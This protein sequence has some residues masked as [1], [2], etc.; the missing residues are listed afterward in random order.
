IQFIDD[1]D[2]AALERAAALLNSLIPRRNRYGIADLLRYAVASSEFMAVIAANFDGAQRV[3]N[4][5]KLFRLAEQFE[6]SGHLIRDFVHFVEEFEAIGGREGEGQMD[7][8]ANVVRLM[9]IHQAKGLEFPIVIIPDLH[10]EPNRREAAF[11]LDR[12]KGV[13]VR[14][15]DGRG[16][17]VRGALFNQLGQR[18]RWRENFESMRLLYVAATRAKDRL[19]FSAAI[20][21]KRLENLDKSELWVGWLWRALALAPHSQTELV[22]V[23]GDAQIHVT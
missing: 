2:L 6:K 5:E 10:R 1:D 22:T 9:T 18:N 20:E 8:S 15:P 11:I 13:T 21:R 12:H 19:I 7:E 23:A 4:V 14:V 3:A 16:R 17:S